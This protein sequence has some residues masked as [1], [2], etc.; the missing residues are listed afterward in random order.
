VPRPLDAT[1]LLGMAVLLAGT[2]L[3]VR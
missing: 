2:W 1:R 3:V